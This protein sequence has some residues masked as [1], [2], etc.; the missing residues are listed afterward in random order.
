VP[1]ALA[2]ID[3][4]PVNQCDL[5]S[6]R[7]CER[8]PAMSYSYSAWLLAV[9]STALVVD[10]CIAPDYSRRPAGDPLVHLL[11]MFANYSDTSRAFLRLRLAPHPAFGT[12]LPNGR[13]D[14]G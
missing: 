3:L 9:K 4:G 12:P 14:R 1:I 6:D 10:C 7:D 11:L 8:Y 2:E 13:G 5:Q